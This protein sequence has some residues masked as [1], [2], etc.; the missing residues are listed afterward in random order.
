MTSAK[1]LALVLIVLDAVSVVVSFNVVGSLRGV[2]DLHDPVIAALQ[3]PV[4]V[5]FLGLYLVDGYSSRTD[6]LSVTY[7]S[8]HVIAQGGV[9][10][11]TLLLTYAVIPGG[12]F[13]LQTSR[14]VT[15]VSYLAIVPVSLGYRRLFYQRAHA[16]DQRHYFLFLGSRED[17]QVFEEECRKNH[18]S[19]A[20]LFATHA[21]FA[22]EGQPAGQPAGVGSYDSVGH[23]LDNYAGRIDAIVVRESIPQLPPA[24]TERL[25]EL[26]F[27]GVP[28]YTYELFSQAYWRKIPLHG[29][30]RTW[31]FQE[32]F[33]I[34]REPV[35]ERLKRLTDILLSL[36]G[37]VLF[38]PLL[39][40][41]G[42]CIR[43]ADGGPVFYRQMRVGLNRRPFE[44]Y[45][46]RTMR[47]HPEGEPYTGRG[48]ARVTPLGRFLRAT[49]IDE[50]PQLWNVLRG[51]MSLIGPR[52][53]W[54]KLVVEYE[55]KIPCYHFRHLVKP[56]ITG[57]AQVNY[58][59]GANLEDTMRKLE[60]DLYY[61][62]FFSFILDASIVL[63]TIHVM[64]GGKGR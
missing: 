23:Y 58:P 4:L 33:Q 6:M 56:G 20:V 46:L 49:R 22:P 9:L 34:G 52:A 19:Q 57:W 53:E 41:L 28:T 51:E 36:V 2:I 14:L 5:H 54:V 24:V 42:P 63:K 47:E 32:G 21:T 44:I 59:Y 35:F 15:A 3:L 55:R 48:D 7:A 64:L 27:S 16:R 50:A 29:L 18:M 13:P 30:S 17:C 39:L 45:K 60:Y 8:L 1:Q 37:L 40:L 25:V 62:R 43:L 38:A 11:V 61:I 31:L 12:D 26:N 10:L